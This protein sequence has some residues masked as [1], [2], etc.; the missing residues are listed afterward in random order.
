VEGDISE[1]LSVFVLE[2]DPV[3]VA[4]LRGFVERIPLLRWSGSASDVPAAEH[5]LRETPACLLVLDIGLPGDDGYRLLGRLP[6]EPAVVVVTGDA[7]HALQGFEHGVVDL[8]VKPFT[9]VRFLQ[10]MQRAR[11]RVHAMAPRDRDAAVPV[12]KTALVLRSGRRTVQVEPDEVLAGEACGNQV[13]LHLR[14]GHLLVG[15]SLG[16]LEDMLSGMDFVRIHRR[17]L[18]A[19][20][21]IHGVAPSH[22]ETLRGVLPLGANYRRELLDRWGS[23]TRSVQ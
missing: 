22:V 10:A 19:W 17:Y 20:H 1:V 16:N 9:F 21:A 4:L 7:A 2:D 13:K 3:Q 5:M 12:G 11:A 18:V 6:Y 15:T 8:L 14:E 23:R